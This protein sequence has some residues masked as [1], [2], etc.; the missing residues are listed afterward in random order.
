MSSRDE[1][2][3][4]DPLDP[5]V[6]RAIRVVQI[7]RGL[8]DGLISCTTH[9][10][11][12]TAQYTAVSYVCGNLD[13]KHAILIDGK[14]HMI[15]KN[16]LEFLQCARE[17]PSS[18]TFWIDAI[19]INQE[20]TDEKSL[21]VQMM[22][23]IFSCAKVVL[24][25][26]GVPTQALT[27]MMYMI[28]VYGSVP[29]EQML[30]VAA[31]D[32]LFW[33]GFQ[34]FT[35]LDYWKR[36]WTVQEFIT[37]NQHMLVAGSSSVARQD[38]A[39]VLQH[40]S[41]LTTPLKQTY[42]LKSPSSLPNMYKA[43]LSSELLF[44]WRLDLDGINKITTLREWWATAGSKLCGDIRDRIYAII[45]LASEQR[46]RID[47]AIDPFHLFLEALWLDESSR[48]DWTIAEPSLKE[49]AYSLI[50]CL[51]LS[52]A[53]IAMYAQRRT[54]GARVLIRQSAWDRAPHLT[55]LHLRA[56][57]S[58]KNQSEWSLALEEP[59]QSNALIS[60]YRDHTGTWGDPLGDLSMLD[61]YFIGIDLFER[62]GSHKP[63]RKEMNLR[64]LITGVPQGPDDNGVDFSSDD[65]T[66]ELD[67]EGFLN[68]T[69]P[70]VLALGIYH[71]RCLDPPW[72]VYYMLVDCHY[73]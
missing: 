6:P 9:H 42:Y 7:E 25:W 65:S 41:K 54:P 31:Y 26:L 21:Q 8:R 30:Q 17:E 4:H 64:L 1:W 71:T 27:H 29:L 34:D 23:S 67:E 45:S 50:H 19:S 37:T 15:G 66:L 48:L 16:L 68:H 53:S 72:K 57:A 40:I 59:S 28:G 43:S 32:T 11:D 10:V 36:A 63:V 51:G 69:E 18:R 49:T 62:L 46:L 13:F 14:R 60:W 47:Y 70:G 3:H 56:S 52:P 58:S 24:T 44:M 20:D 35:S 2:F 38:F 73:L 5:E 55:D 61:G 22:G 33:N 12:T 39:K